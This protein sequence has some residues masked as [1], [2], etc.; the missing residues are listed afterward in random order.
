[1]GGAS[2]ATGYRDGGAQPVV[3]LAK[4][5]GSKV[6]PMGRLTVLVMGMAVA[7]LTAA[8]AG[9]VTPVHSAPVLPQ[10]FTNSRS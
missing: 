4:A 8:L 9:S 1:M 5:G 7:A 10:G 6:K 3:T 2:G